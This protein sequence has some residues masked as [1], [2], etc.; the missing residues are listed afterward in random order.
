M[1][2]EVI[3]GEQ[4][5]AGC[6]CNGLCGHQADD[7]AA[8]KAR[9]CRR[10]DGVDITQISAGIGKGRFDD[11][12]QGLDMG[13]GGDLGHDAA[14]CRMLGDLAEHGIGQDSRRG[15]AIQRHDAGRRLVTARLYAQNA[16]QFA[17]NLDDCRSATSPLGGRQDI[18]SSGSEPGLS[19]TALD[20]NNLEDWNP[21]QPSGAWHRRMK[22]ATG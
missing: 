8:D 5:L 11:A 20:A 21:R 2:L 9:A 22:R 15:S 17:A 7:Q 3:D 16:D 4:R 13:A 19:R 12:I 18:R 14:E 10:C 6:G 1:A